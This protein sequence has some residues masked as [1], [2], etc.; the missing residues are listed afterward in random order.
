MVSCFLDAD[1]PRVDNCSGKENIEQV[2][3]LPI[4][5]CQIPFLVSKAGLKRCSIWGKPFIL[6]QFSLI[7]ID[8]I[9]FCILGEMSASKGDEA[10]AEYKKALEV[11][12]ARKSAPKRAA[13]VEDDEVQFLRSSKRLT[14]AAAA[15]SSS[16]KKSKAS[17]SS[18]SA[19]YDWAIVLTNLNTKVFPSTP[20][21]LASDLPSYPRDGTID[22]PPAH[23]I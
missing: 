22:T 3:R 4:E 7:V 9:R 14:V 21:L 19:S 12:C 16:K 18:P 13:F 17:G 10:L 8:W 15:P 6:F 5:R 2:L 23:Q 11:M 1:L 20:V